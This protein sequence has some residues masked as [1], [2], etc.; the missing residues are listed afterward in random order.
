MKYINYIKYRGGG[1]MLGGGLGRSMHTQHGRMLDCCV[2]HMH[3][4]TANLNS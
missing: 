1:E 4:S 3:A 2:V